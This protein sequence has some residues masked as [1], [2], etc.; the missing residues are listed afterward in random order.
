MDNGQNI[1]I[2]DF[3]KHFMTGTAVHTNEILQRSVDAC[4]LLVLNQI[5]IAFTAKNLIKFV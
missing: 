5:V 3:S 4:K 1:D 2:L